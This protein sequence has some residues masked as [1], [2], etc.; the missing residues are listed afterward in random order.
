MEQRQRQG[1]A[2]LPFLEAYLLNLACDDPS[3]VLGPQL[4][5]PILQQRLLAKA[6]QFH[7]FRAASQQTQVAQV[8]WPLLVG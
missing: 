1:Q 5:L 7:D 3:T 2:V 8:P 6:R 4:L